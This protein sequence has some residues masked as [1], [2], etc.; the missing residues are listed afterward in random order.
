MFVQICVTIHRGVLSFFWVV[1]ACLYTQERKQRVRAET[2]EQSIP[3]S[4]FSWV[5]KPRQR[6][7]VVACGVCWPR[8]S[9]SPVGREGAKGEPPKRFQ[10]IT[11]PRREL[12][13]LEIHLSSSSYLMSLFRKA[14]REPSL[15]D[16]FLLFLST[17]NGLKQTMDKSLG[18]FRFVTAVPMGGVSKGPTVLTGRIP[19]TRQ[20][21]VHYLFFRC[22]MLYNRIQ[23]HICQPRCHIRFRMS[24]NKGYSTFVL[25]APQVPDCAGFPLGIECS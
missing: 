7:K 5:A 9:H 3:H 23:N 10:L 20:L 24:R 6:G 11:L 25:E 2:P 13:S 12:Q 4:A 15:S 22:S 17:V 19:V 8:R 21:N 1:Q 18:F 16:F 14:T